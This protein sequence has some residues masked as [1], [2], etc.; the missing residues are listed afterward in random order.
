MMMEAARAWDS[1]YARGLAGLLVVWCSDVR[2]AANGGWRRHQLSIGYTTN[3]SCEMDFF[4]AHLC[5]T[6]PLEGQLY[7]GKMKFVEGASTDE[8]RSGVYV[9]S[10]AVEVD[11]AV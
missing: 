2:C 10:T 3:T 6:R 4:D 11:K 1:F 8:H 7:A 5:S 9:G